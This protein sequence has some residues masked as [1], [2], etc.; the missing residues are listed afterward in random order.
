MIKISDVIHI[1]RSQ[2]PR[3][4]RRRSAAAPFLGLWVQIPPVHT[5]RSLLSVVFRQVEVSVLGWSLVQKSPTEC[6]ATECVLEAS[7]M[8]RS[9]PTG[10][11]DPWRKA[12]KR[13]LYNNG[14]P[15]SLRRLFKLLAFLSIHIYSDIFPHW[16]YI[17]ISSF[18]PYFLCCCPLVFS[19]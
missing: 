15:S 6:G 5:C 3:G 10:A 2:W 17:S 13:F 16:R 4:L 12:P 8:R 1:R 14:T 11:T 7:M 18:R 19:I 9:R